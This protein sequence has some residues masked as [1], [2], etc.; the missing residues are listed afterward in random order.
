MLKK[1]LKWLGFTLILYMIA[2]HIEDDN[3]DE[4]KDGK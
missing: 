1:L 4:D 2:S 3:S